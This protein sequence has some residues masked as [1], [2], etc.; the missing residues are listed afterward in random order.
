M[1]K[2]GFTLV[3]LSIVIIIIGLLVTS[4]VGGQKIVDN[5]KANK[6]INNV[7]TIKSSAS[8]FQTTFDAIPGDFNEAYSYW[9][10]DCD[11]SSSECNG[12]DDGEIDSSAATGET[13][14]ESKFFFHHLNLAGIL[15]NTYDPTS[16]TL[17]DYLFDFSFYTYGA[18][19]TALYDDGTSGYFHEGADNYLLI[20]TGSAYDEA[21]ISPR[22]AYKL[23][24]KIDDGLPE[25]GLVTIY[26][27][28]SSLD[29]ACTNGTSAYYLA[30][31]TEA[32]NLAISIY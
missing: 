14:T 28:D 27:S 19:G 10:T 13:Y 24:S 26:I 3:E 15:N 20:G 29:T 16:S 23:D 18:Y 8:I 2:R 30:S 25:S 4:I 31:D 6:L 1:F 7:N 21:F 5:A 11:S 32:C 22:W 17:T 12:D 9:T